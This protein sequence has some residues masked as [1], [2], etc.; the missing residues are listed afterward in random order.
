MKLVIGF[1]AGI[2]ATAAINVAAQCLQEGGLTPMV[3]IF[4]MRTRQKI[5]DCKVT[6]TMLDGHQIMCQR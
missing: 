5:A 6:I 3:Q 4:D 2:A 1:L